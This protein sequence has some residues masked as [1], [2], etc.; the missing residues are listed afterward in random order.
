MN[1]VYYVLPN[2]LD[3]KLVAIPFGLDMYIDMWPLK[4]KV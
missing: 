3:L 2:I 1:Y 4:E